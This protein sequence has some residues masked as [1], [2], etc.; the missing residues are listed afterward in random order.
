MGDLQSHRFFLATHSLRL[1]RH[2]DIISF[3]PT[4]YLSSTSTITS[5][6][7]NWFSNRLFSPTNAPQ[8][9]STSR[10]GNEQTYSPD[11]VKIARIRF[12]YLG[13]HNVVLILWSG[14]LD[15]GI[16]GCKS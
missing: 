14:I 6:S 15:V 10:A 12:T 9:A 11:F 16:A 7:P 4:T 8:A 1:R 13:T 2:T 3:L 5:P